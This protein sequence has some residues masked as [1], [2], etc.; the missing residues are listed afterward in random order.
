[1]IF[2]NVISVI[3]TNILT[4]PE[5]EF[6]N[7]AL[8]IL[9]VYSLFLISIGTIIVH[10]FSFSRFF[11]T[12]ILTLFGMAIVVFVGFLVW[13]IIQQMLGFIATIISEIIYR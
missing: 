8:K 7:V 4:T 1:M 5:S 2:G 3:A 13:M 6:L 12:A 11:A 10:D 9:V